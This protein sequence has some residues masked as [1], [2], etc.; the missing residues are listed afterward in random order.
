M[1]ATLH[2]IGANG[3]TINLFSNPYFTL[4]HVDGMTG[5]AS[6]IAAATV[7]SMDGDRVNNI[8]TQPRSIILDLRIKQA[9][10]VEDAKRYILRTVKPKQTGRLVF[11][12]NGRDIEI[13]G[14]VESISMPRFEKSVMMQVTLHC[15]EPYWHDVEDVL[16]EISR[17]LDMH[18]FPLDV[19][20]LA[21]PV[22]GVVMGEYDLNMTRTYTNDGDAE[23]GVVITIIALSKVVNPAI[24]KADG[25][26]IGVSDTMETGDEIV[27]NT[28]RGEKGITKNGANILS[29]IMPGST[30]IQL[31]TGDNELTVDS[32]GDTEGNVYFTLSFKRRFV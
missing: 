32:D 12:Q 3:N 22:D 28:N 30:F 7:P 6:D 2:Y 24:Y 17:V 4:E 16:L 19:G 25:T 18:Y 13:S 21:F 1:A 10:N 9:A 15:S 14:A 5:V 26:Y 11:S 27:I 29:K 8:R 23:C 31:D 20:G